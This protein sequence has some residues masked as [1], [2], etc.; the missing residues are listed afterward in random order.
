MIYKR[1]EAKNG[2]IMYFIGESLDK[3]GKL[4]KGHMAKV[5]EIPESVYKQLEGNMTLE[6]GAKAPVEQVAPD[7]APQI[8]REDRK[9]FIDGKPGPF[10]KFLQLQTVYL[11]EEHQHSLTTGEVVYEMRKAGI[12]EDA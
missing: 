5:E 8:R 3:K 7:E 2:R 11:C 4:V 1:T 10:K 9:C 12:L 6:I